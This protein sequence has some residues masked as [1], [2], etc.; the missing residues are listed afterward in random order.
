MFKI[1]HLLESL[2]IQ[3]THNHIATAYVGHMLQQ[4]AE[5]RLH[6]TSILNLLSK[7]KVLDAKMRIVLGAF[8]ST[9]IDEQLVGFST[10]LLDT[11]VI[12]TPQSAVE[13]MKLYHNLAVNKYTQTTALSACHVLSSI[14]HK[15][16][17]RDE[18]ATKLIKAT[19]STNE[20]GYILANVGLL[21]DIVTLA[22][23]LSSPFGN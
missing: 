12:E 17:I 16:G 1:L 21:Y 14:R 20:L 22:N 13:I 19:K 3:G 8:M 5:F 11:I 4:K 18:Q 6:K 7:I 23:T 9:L 10:H 2:D 15:L